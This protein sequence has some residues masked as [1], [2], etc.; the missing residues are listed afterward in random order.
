MVFVGM[1]GA[2]GERD[3]RCEKYEKRWPQW[4]IGLHRRVFLD[5]RRVCFF[6][7][8]CPPATHTHTPHSPMAIKYFLLVNKQGQTR[9]ARY[10][11]P[12][13]PLAERVALEGEIVRKA[14][15]RSD[16]QVCLDEC[17]CGVG[18]V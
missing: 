3:G 8:F 12:L 10:A 5:A 13:P 17:V 7:F 15:S 18:L 9:L 16:K 2:G 4:G 14:L 6:F 1:G 11:A